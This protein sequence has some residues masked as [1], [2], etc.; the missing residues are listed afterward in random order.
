MR[1][2]NGGVD[3]SWRPSLGP[4][5]WIGPRFGSAIR[6]WI[7]PYSVAIQSRAHSTPATLRSYSIGLLKQQLVQ[8]RGGVAA[9]QL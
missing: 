1:D 3:G 8:I 9:C 6:P 4:I 5:F 7:A 2:M